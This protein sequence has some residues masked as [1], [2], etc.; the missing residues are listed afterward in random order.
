[1]TNEKKSTIYI[2]LLLGAFFV[3]LAFRLIRLGSLALSNMEADIT[4][5]AL[6]VARGSDTLFTGHTAYIGLTGFGFHLL[7]ASNFLARFWPALVGGL[8][9]FVPYL[10]RDW[11]GKWPAAI[12]SFILAISP[13]MVGLSRIVGSP[14]MAVVFLL[15]ALGFLLHRKPVPT[16]MCLALGLMSGYGFWIGVL[17]LGL[18]Y[19]IVQLIINDSDNLSFH[20]PVDG[21]GFW[22]RLGLSFVITLV[23]VGTGFFL[24]SE[25][26]S[27]IFSGLLA[28]IKGFFTPNAV[29]LS[30]IFLTLVAYTA[31]AVVFGV[32]GGLR[33]IVTR[34]KLDV[35]LLIWSGLGLV[36]MLVY[37]AAE[38]ADMVWVMLPL[39][40]LSA[41]VA[42]S[43]WRLP[44]TSRWVMILTALLVV[45]LSAFILFTLRS[46]VGTSLDQTRR[47]YAFIALVAALVLLLV[48]IILVGLGWSEDVALPGLLIGLAVVFCVGLVSLSVNGTGIAPDESAEL[49]YAQE[50][51]LHPE[52]LTLT[53]D[54]VITWNSRA[55]VEPVEIAVSGYDTPGVQWALRDYDHVQFVPYLAAESQPGILITDVLEIPEI[56]SSY[57]GQDLVW[58]K[59]NLWGEMTPFQYLNW[60]ITRDAPTSSSEIIFWVRTD[61]MPNDQLAQ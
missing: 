56:S 59:T 60:L 4:L 55:G 23:V 34:S 46:L 24:S 1:M 9:V 10:F 51:R 57:T 53:I 17:L 16:G 33:G 18:S 27:G 15:L 42:F 13:E 45:V 14:M 32:W 54:R 29:P 28:F 2:M 39:W 6:S 36:F 38:T 40:M 25:N 37:P 44:D 22:I 30:L 20:P 58:A 41:R 61:L 48:V 7:D 50:A 8:V 26:L 3:A 31:E 5:Q 47:L 49:W 43:A 52:M 19:L 11:I 35:F 12:L 21:R